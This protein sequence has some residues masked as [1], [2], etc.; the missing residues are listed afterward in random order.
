MTIK[1]HPVVFALIG[2]G[3]IL[4]I[5]VLLLKAFGGLAQ[6]SNAGEVARINQLQNLTLTGRVFD[7]SRNSV[8]VPASAENGQSSYLPP[9]TAVEVLSIQGDTALVR[10]RGG[11]RLTYSVDKSFLGWFNK[12]GL[13]PMYEPV[14][15]LTV[16]VEMKPNFPR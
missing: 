1:V 15:R 16:P 7:R 10:T 4:S 3:V 12:N 8:M 13:P 2:L 11:N 6:I 14:Y 5:L 9:E